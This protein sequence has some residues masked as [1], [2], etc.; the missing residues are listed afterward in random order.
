MKLNRT[1]ILCLFC[2]AI[3]S[4]LSGDTKTQVIE[5]KVLESWDTD[6]GGWEVYGAEGI[7]EGYPKVVYAPSWPTARFG[8]NP[9]DKDMKSLGIKAAFDWKGNNRLE[10]VPVKKD[11]EGKSVPREIE[12]PGRVQSFDVWVWGS[13]YN[14]DL[15]VHL[16]DYMGFTHVLSFGNLK[17]TGWKHLS[18]HVPNAIPQARGHIPAFRGLKLTKL[19][20][21]TKPAEDVS[22][23]YIYLDH[24]SILTDMFESPFDGVEMTRPEYL[25]EVWGEK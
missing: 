8:A 6:E 1:L 20:L 12:I 23:F 22:G 9:E 14:F 21:W 5:S 2:I 15:E 19:V 4:G 11:A 24:L 17:F 13:N 25:E 18:V 3:L 7:A 16:M 10:I